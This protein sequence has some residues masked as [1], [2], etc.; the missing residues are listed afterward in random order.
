M[1]VLLIFVGRP[2]VATGVRDIVTED[3]TRAKSPDILGVRQ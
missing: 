2:I 3:L 1:V